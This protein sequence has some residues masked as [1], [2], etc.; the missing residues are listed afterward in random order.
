MLGDVAAEKY[1]SIGS[2][3]EMAIKVGI[4]K[5]QLQWPIS[6]MVEKS[7]SAN[8]IRPLEIRLFT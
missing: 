2:V 1:L 5:W 4:G 8:A 6:E 7:L 3:W